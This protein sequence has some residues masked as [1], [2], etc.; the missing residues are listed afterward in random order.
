MVGWSLVQTSRQDRSRAELDARTAARD[1]AHALR[2]ALRAPAVLTLLP[3]SERFVVQRG[4]V[5]IDP[6]VGWLRERET[7]QDTVVAEKLRM[8]Q[9]A[10][11]AHGDAAAAAAHFEELLDTMGPSPSLPVLAA[12]AWQAQRAGANERASELGARLDQ[13]L[14]AAPAA[15]TADRDLA[16]AVS[17]AALFAT[18]AGRSR[19]AWTDRL[20]P[21]LAPDLGWPT[22]D[23]L[24]ERGA[25]VD[26][27]R[28][29]LQHTAAR[30][31]LLATVAE[32]LQAPA[33]TPGATA[34]SGRLLLWFPDEGDPASGRGALTSTELLAALRGLGTNRPEVPGLPPVPECCTLV[35]TR[36]DVEAEEVVPQLVWVTAPPLPEPPWFAQPTAVMAAG[37]ALVAVFA[38]SAFFTVRGPA[39]RGP[40]DARAGRVPH[41]RHARTEDSGRGDPPRRRRADRRRRAARQAAR[42]LRAAR[43]RVGTAVDAGRERA[44]PRSD[45]TR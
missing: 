45:G 21:S 9:V 30:R 31:A 17:A 34:V 13:T 38:A 2:A 7:V 6:E 40:R 33:P 39:P 16:R 18:A 14:D 26:S 20:L 10:E 8:A 1:L 12:A 42:V 19:A 32:H 35:F 15:A 43:R 41:G 29:Q 23:R 25:D 4:T 28:T 37:L 24:A 27:L 36:P 44:R 5:Q 11:F 22:L 3:A